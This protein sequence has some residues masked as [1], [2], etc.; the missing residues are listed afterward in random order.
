MCNELARLTSCSITTQ[1]K[2]P[3]LPFSGTGFIR[4]V[5]FVRKRLVEKAVLSFFVAISS[6]EGRGHAT[7]AY[8]QRLL[9]RIS[10]PRRAAGNPQQGEGHA[11]QV[12]ESSSSCPTVPPR[13]RSPPRL[14]GAL[15]AAQKEKT[16]SGPSVAPRLMSRSRGEGSSELPL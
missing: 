4:S 13:S 9:F 3:R 15:T 5:K 11:C 6:R 14:P 12:F 8:A 1:T 10:G 16:F 7:E 2:N